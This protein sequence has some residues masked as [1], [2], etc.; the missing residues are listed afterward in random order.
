MLGVKVCYNTGFGRPDCD[1]LEAVGDQRAAQRAEGVCSVQQP[2][3]GGGGWGAVV[4][5]KMNLQ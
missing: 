1:I 4:A 5:T 2:E 3:V